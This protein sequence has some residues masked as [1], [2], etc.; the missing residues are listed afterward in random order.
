MNAVYDFPNLQNIVF[1]DLVSKLKT[2]EN[3]AV[4]VYPDPKS[5]ALANL[6]VLKQLGYFKEK[7]LEKELGN[8]EKLKGIY[9]EIDWD[10]FNIKNESVISRLIENRT[11]A[12]AKE[13]FAKNEEEKKLFDD[14]AVKMFEKGSVKFKGDVVN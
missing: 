4:K 7:T 3:D 13:Q 12:M 6:Y 14:W 10:L 11:F 8:V 2:P 1:E 5:T 9:P